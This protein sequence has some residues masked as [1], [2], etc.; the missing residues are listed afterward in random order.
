[1]NRIDELFQKKQNNILSIYFTAG[2]PGLN[3]TI[4]IIKALE[5]SGVDMIE[6][7]MP[8]SDPMADG[9]VIQQSSLKALNNG[10]SLNLL[11]E[12]LK[13]IRKE[14][15][16][17]LLLMGYLNPVFRY[18]IEN[19]CAKCK[20][21]GI[22]GLIVPDLPIDD[23]EE[24]YISVFEKANLYNVFLVTP[25]TSDDRIKCINKLSKGFMYMVSS[26][27][28]TGSGKGLEQSQEYFERMKTMKSSVPKVIGFGI[29]DKSTFN[30]ACQFANGAIIGTAFVSAMEA[31]GSIE[32]KVEKFIGSIR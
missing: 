4:T 7:G 25:Q 1:M 23:Y 11:F 28:T 9:P 15:K 14:V 31:E 24:K 17:P 2:H 32:S 16:I 12:Q 21:V 18:G 3:D 19:F 10:M 5:K 13:D 22:D 30:N 29:K 6:I 26:F 27:S 20:E 8:F